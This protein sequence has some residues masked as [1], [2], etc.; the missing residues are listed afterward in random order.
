M[1]QATMGTMGDKEMVTDLLTTQKQITGT[2]NTYAGECKCIE[3]R[4]TFLNLL[5][6]E[7]GIQSELFTEMNSRG[8]YPT[9]EAPITDIS[10]AK[11]KF[12]QA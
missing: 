3:L 4:D 11:Q 12:T 8:W 10:T 9:K 6:E 1:T 7:H 2:Y 5:K